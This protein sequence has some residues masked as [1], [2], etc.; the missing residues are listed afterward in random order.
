MKHEICIRSGSE[1]ITLF[2]RTI[3]FSRTVISVIIV[4]YTYTIIFYTFQKSIYRF[5]VKAVDGGTPPLSDSTTVEIE[6]ED[7]NDNAPIFKQCDITAV[8]QAQN[9]S[10]R[11][12]N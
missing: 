12:I 3:I 4:Q 5:T 9:L 8:V 11:S 6:V 10:I 7:E 1:D 2:R